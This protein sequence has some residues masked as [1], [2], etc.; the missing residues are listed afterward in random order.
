[1]LFTDELTGLDRTHG[2]P[3]RTPMG[4]GKTLLL[5][6]STTGIVLNPVVKIVRCGTESFAFADSIP[7]TGVVRDVELTAYVEVTQAGMPTVRKGI[8]Y[9]VECSTD[10]GKTWASKARW[11]DVWQP[12]KGAS[13]RA[14]ETSD[15]S[16]VI[17]SVRGTL[18]L[19]PQDLFASRQDEHFPGS[20]M[21]QKA[22]KAILKT[23]L[24][25]KAPIAIWWENRVT[26]NSALFMATA[27][28]IPL[29]TP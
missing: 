1:M 25:Q 20:W 14:A 23:S 24:R 7:F 28:T 13:A 21:M 27:T 3:G 29:L 8:P 16:D 10:G 9:T 11:G 15:K 2:R 12:D 17:S 18:Y 4:G 19:P 6:P 22:R 5:F 26:T